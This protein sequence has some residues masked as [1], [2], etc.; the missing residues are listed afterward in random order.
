M[1]SRS[2]RSS[3]LEY[4][5][6]GGS[7]IVGLS[8]KEHNAVTGLAD[9]LYDFLPGSGNQNWRGHIT[10]A[11]VAAK[12]GVG[13]H[14][15]GGSK[16]PAIVALLSQTLERERSRFEPLILEI[17]KQAI[18]YRQKN[19]SPV[20]PE[21]VD[22]LNGHILELGFKFP[23]LWDPDVKNAQRH[24]PGAAREAAR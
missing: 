4:R 15:Q 10:F 17:V 22:L 21:D 14:W 2:M 19:G 20:T 9:V 6:A 8:L 18:V 16:K 23:A 1:K 3:G 24:G 13:N 7:G 5:E 11:S 12:A